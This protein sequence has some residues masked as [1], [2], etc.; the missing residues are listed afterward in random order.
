MR[1]SKF[2]ITTEPRSFCF[3]LPK[4]V[5]IQLKHKIDSIIG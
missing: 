5:G 1:D 3:G 4:D 2:V